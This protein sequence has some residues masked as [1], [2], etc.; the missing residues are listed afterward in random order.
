MLMMKMEGMLSQILQN[1]KPNTR[2]ITR[3]KVFLQQI[4]NGATVI[5]RGPAGRQL[6]SQLATT[7]GGV[8][9]LKCK[10]HLTCQSLE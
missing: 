6:E 4:S 5:T 2:P 1:M 9:L 8:A 10:C 3:E 7:T